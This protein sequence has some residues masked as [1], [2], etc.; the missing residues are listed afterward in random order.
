MD[1]GGL[2]AKWDAVESIRVRFRERQ[3]LMMLAPGSNWVEPNRQN[4]VQHSDLLL[5]ALEIL[6]LTPS[7]KLPYLQSLQAEIGDLYE[8]LG[9]ANEKF[10]YRNAQE[11]KR[12]LGLVKRKALKKELT[13]DRYP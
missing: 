5:P 8:R 2:S 3:D 12:L 10:I 13:K 7:H 9:Q 6:R 11:I 4:A 1:C